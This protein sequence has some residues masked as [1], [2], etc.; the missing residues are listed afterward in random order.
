[1]DIKGDKGAVVFEE[2]AVLRADAFAEFVPESERGRQSA[3]IHV[4]DEAFPAEFVS[5]AVPFVAAVRDEDEALA[6]A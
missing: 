6:A 2:G 4:C 1:V 5:V 3:F